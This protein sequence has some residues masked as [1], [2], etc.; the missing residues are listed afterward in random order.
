MKNLD[1]KQS[2]ILQTDESSLKKWESPALLNE[3][4]GYTLGGA[5]PS[6]AENAYCFT[7]PS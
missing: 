4:L 7:T 2:I 3:E 5:F 6:T 1:N